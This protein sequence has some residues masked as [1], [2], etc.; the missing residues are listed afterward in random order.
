MGC[1]AEFGLEGAETKAPGARGDGRGVPQGPRDLGVP[2]GAGSR[3]SSEW[4]VLLFGALA[5]VCMKQLCPLS[6]PGNGL[7]LLTPLSP[8]YRGYRS[9]L[10]SLAAVLL[11]PR[12]LQDRFLCVF[13][14]N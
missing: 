6:L 8:G 4:V 14:P 10:G 7:G 1:E 5:R 12:R 13:E 2:W 9:A 11:T 3:E